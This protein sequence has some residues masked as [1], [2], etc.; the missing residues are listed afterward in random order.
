MKANF[1][2]EV[3]DVKD[4]VEEVTG[5]R[6]AYTSLDEMEKDF[7]NNDICLW[8]YPIN[9]VEHIIENSLNVCIVRFEDLYG[10]YEH[11][12]CELR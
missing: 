3:W 1:D 10:G 6:P 12:W 7:E 11:R 2:N 5:C 4:Y 9:E 8:N